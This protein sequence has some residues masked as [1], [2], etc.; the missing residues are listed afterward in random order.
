M[1]PVFPRRRFPWLSNEFVPARVWRGTERFQYPGWNFPVSLIQTAGGRKKLY[2]LWNFSISFNRWSFTEQL[3]TAEINV[4]FV[5]RAFIVP[6]F[7]NHISEKSFPCPLEGARV[8]PL[9]VGSPNKTGSFS[10]ASCGSK[11]TSRSFKVGESFKFQVS[12]SVTA[13]W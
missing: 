5:W 12:S 4:T 7:C 13:N 3:N 8:E 1:E 9:T 2:Y 10:L 6:A 11:C